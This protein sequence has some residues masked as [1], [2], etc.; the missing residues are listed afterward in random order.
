MQDS[1]HVNSKW[2]NPESVMS[3][4]RHK[5]STYG[6]LFLFLWGFIILLYS[7]LMAFDL[8][9]YEGGLW[10]QDYRLGVHLQMSANPYEQAAENPYIR[11]APSYPDEGYIISYENSVTIKLSDP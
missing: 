9:N 3:G 4:I 10:H 7:V 6:K 8:T 11:S 5:I 1:S 2:I